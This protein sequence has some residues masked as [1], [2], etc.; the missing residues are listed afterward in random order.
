M[1]RDKHAL[2]QT[3]SLPIHAFGL[4]RQLHFGVLKAAIKVDL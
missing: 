2:R 1:Q 3:T 4:I